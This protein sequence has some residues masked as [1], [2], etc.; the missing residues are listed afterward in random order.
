M[1]FILALLLFANVYP[2]PSE[3]SYGGITL[4][5]EYACGDVG[6][7]NFVKIMSIFY[8]CINEVLQDCIVIDD[9]FKT[10]L[11]NPWSPGDEEEI[12]YD[13]WDWKTANGFWPRGIG[14]GELHHN[15]TK[16]TVSIISYP[17]FLDAAQTLREDLDFFYVELPNIA[18][19]KQRGL[20]EK[21]NAIDQE[22]YRAIEIIDQNDIT[23]H[24]YQGGPCSGRV[25]IWEQID[26]IEWEIKRGEER[27][28]N[29][30]NQY[31]EKRALVENSIQ[32]IDA[33]FKRIFVYCLKNHQVEGTTFTTAIEN[34]IGGD[35]DSALK[36][37]QFMIDFAEKR[38]MGN[39]LVAKLYLLKGQLQSEF[40][41]YADAVIGLT[42][43]IQKNPSQKEA[44]IE[45]AAAYFE[46]GEFDHAIEDYLASDFGKSYPD[47]KIAW[48]QIPLISSGIAIG[49]VEGAGQSAL[50]FIPETLSTV[51]G[52][53]NGLWAFSK[54]PVGASKEFVDA[55]LKCVEYIRKNTNFQLA[56]DII[57]ELKELVETYDQISDFQKGKLI[58][59]I[60]GKYGTDILICKY[61]V[62][63]IKAYQDLKRANQLM[64]LEA[65]ASPKN[66]EKH[67]QEASQKLWAQRKEFLKST[68]LKIHWGKQEKHIIGAK[69]YEPSRNR[70][71]F[72]HDDPEQLVKK[73]AGTGIKDSPAAP[74]TSGYKEVVNFE[75]KIGL[76]VDVVTG[77]QFET[78]WG[79]IHYAKDGVH[80]VPFKPKNY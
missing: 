45:R 9:S 1:R 60:I 40:C 11:I 21:L 52:L 78:C 55:A 38:T 53:G 15:P 58:G 12:W 32:R 62:K 48:S 56:Q 24:E 54:D 31:Q 5:C 7:P 4:E 65:L 29:F 67:L 49:I 66:F 80:I 73:F 39:E 33:C 22:K 79:K 27:L 61:S 59:H 70:S 77:E 47:H 43:S 68:N 46:L 6:D 71:I 69:N 19:E 18:I 3:V 8:E 72:T 35:Y 44:Y 76:V 34:L 14:W 28:S 20:L 63:A 57:P 50:E 37:V 17:N 16:T 26:S 23:F 30:E 2:I 42:T 51:R 36:Q 10:R 75:E 13:R 74:G 25:R 41:L 64:T